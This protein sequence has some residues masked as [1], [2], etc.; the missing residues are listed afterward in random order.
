MA[1]KRLSDAKQRKFVKE[2]HAKLKDLKEKK[3]FS[4]KEINEL[5]VLIA[6]KLG[7]VE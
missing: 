3:K 1:I 7:I 6:K 4:Q 5:V 2:N